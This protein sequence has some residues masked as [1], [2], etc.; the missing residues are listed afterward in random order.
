MYYQNLKKVTELFKAPANK[1]RTNVL[2]LSRLKSILAAL[3]SR[4]KQWPN[5]KNIKLLITISFGFSS[6]PLTGIVKF[7][8]K[9]NNFKSAKRKKLTKNNRASY[10]KS[11][12]QFQTDIKLACLISLITTVR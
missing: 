9:V 11:V 2:H 5:L 8:S 1:F 10:K 4:Q 7:N 3:Y 12:N 6:T